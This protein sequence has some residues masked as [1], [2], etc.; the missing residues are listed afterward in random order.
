LTGKWG[1]VLRERSV[2]STVENTLDALGNMEVVPRA[3]AIRDQ[4]VGLRACS[5]RA[6]KRSHLPRDFGRF[7]GPGN[8]ASAD[9]VTDVVASSAT[10]GFVILE[11]TRKRTAANGGSLIVR[12]LRETLAVRGLT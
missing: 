6:P 7:E 8:C 3:A 5:P 10:D 1:I 11:I 12:Q 9:V 2:L 4:G